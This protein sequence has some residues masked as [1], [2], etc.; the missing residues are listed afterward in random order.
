[1]AQAQPWPAGRS[2]RRDTAPQ[3]P[4]GREGVAGEAG[5]PVPLR[6]PGPAPGALPPGPPDGW[7]EGQQA[8]P[9]LPKQTPENPEWPLLSSRRKLRVEW[10][11]SPP[12]ILPQAACKAGASRTPFF[13]RQSPSSPCPSDISFPSRSV[14][15]GF[16]K[17]RW[18]P[19]RPDFKPGNLI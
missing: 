15:Q 2:P 4:P 10:Q 17:E 11:A 12:G 8:P 19:R 5:A 7:A 1:M 14:P 6:E 18:G 3:P 16:P 13:S 9:L